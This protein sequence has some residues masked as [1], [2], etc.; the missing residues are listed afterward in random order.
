MCQRLKTIYRWKRGKA[1]SLAL[2]TLTFRLVMTLVQLLTS[3]SLNSSRYKTDV[4]CSGEVLQSQREAHMKSGTTYLLFP[5]GHGKVLCPL[6]FWLHINCCGVETDVFPDNAGN[7][8][9]WSIKRL[10][11]GREPID[12]CWMNDNQP[13]K[14]HLSM[15]KLLNFLEPP[16]PHCIM[17]TSVSTPKEEDVT[18]T[19][20]KKSFIR[21][22]LCIR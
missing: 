1:Q 3:A 8:S 5:G 7:F 9:P 12:V 2:R 20:S 19:N 14:G 21:T 17:E 16:F 11:Y 15:G 10:T 18:H 4:P 22:M 6:P 13:R